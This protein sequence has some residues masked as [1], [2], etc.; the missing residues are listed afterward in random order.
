MPKLFYELVLTF[1]DNEVVLTFYFSTPI[2]FADLR[3]PKMGAIT[4]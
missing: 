3:F 4:L 2:S 1:F